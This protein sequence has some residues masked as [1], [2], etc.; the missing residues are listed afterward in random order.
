VTAGAGP[1]EQPPAAGLTG[2]EAQDRLARYGPNM[3]AEERPRRMRVLL[4]KLS[5]PVPWML[6]ATVILEAAA[7][8]LVEAVIVAALVVFNGV[9]GFAQEGRA[10]GALALLRSRLAVRARVCRDGRW[11]LTDADGLVPG[12]LVHVRLG[13]IVPADIAVG[14]GTV[15][16]DQ[17]VLTGESAE[18]ETG[19][20]GTLYAGSV[21]RAGEVTGQVTATG[22]RT[23]FGRTAELVRTATTASHLEDTIFKVVRSL[24]IMDGA[25]VV[26]VLAYGIA[27]GLPASELLPFVLILLVAT[28]PVALQATFTLATSL[29]AVQLA[30]AGVLVTHL[31]AVEEAAAMDLVCADKTGTLTQNRLSVLAVRPYGTHAEDEVLAL[32]AAASDEATQDPID[33]AVLAAATARHATPMGRRA[34]FVPFDPAVKRSEAVVD[35]AG[36]RSRVVKGAPAAV[37]ALT[38]GQPRLDAD[39]AALAATGAR[40]LAVAAGTGRL[41]LAGLIA[42]GDPLRPDAAA[43]IGRLRQLGV[44]V[45]M[46]TG[47]TAATALAVARQLGIGDRLGP[48]QLQ[49]A[50][51]P[52]PPSPAQDPPPEEDL[53]FDVVAGCCPRT[54][55]GWSNAP[56]GPGM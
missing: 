25:L 45:V 4:G 16:A 20:G 51:R 29:G 33:L 10:R 35:S 52:H 30:G 9:L 39:V 6:E 36:T 11:Q 31:T 40:V 14:G 48:G 12:D 18:V 37:A 44:R 13:D 41:E 46:V 22:A 49:P 43:I 7:G 21:I 56:S 27:T 32:A 15:R 34:G 55:C 47:D 23:Y 8:K 19:P 28:V 54:S 26:A 17:S 53:G 42:L 38:G 5:G 24:L 2:A 3:V 50:Q 1:G